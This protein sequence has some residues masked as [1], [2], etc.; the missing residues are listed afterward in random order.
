MKKLRFDVF[1]IA[2]EY[3]K[4][5]IQFIFIRA[6]YLYSRTICTDFGVNFRMN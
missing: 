1:F 4:R 5:Y 6:L 2:V 3:R